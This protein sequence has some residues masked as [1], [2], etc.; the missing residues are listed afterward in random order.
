MYVANYGIDHLYYNNGNNTF[1]DV[2]S[3]LG[4]QTLDQSE[5][6]VS[7]DFNRDGFH[8]LFVVN[9][10]DS[11]K[12]WQNNGN[13]NKWVG[14]SLRGFGANSFAVGAKV[15]AVLGRQSQ[16][17]EVFS[18]LSKSS[19]PGFFVVF[20]LGSYADPAKVQIEW[21][22]GEIQEVSNVEINR[23]VPIWRNEP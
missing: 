9:Y 7:A 8:D 6:A 1:T 4:V 2:T 19:S 15:K 3:Q 21:P 20:G 10:N 17:H 14:I 18:T 23:Y 11:N 5:A 12:L 16:L 13:Q 22:D